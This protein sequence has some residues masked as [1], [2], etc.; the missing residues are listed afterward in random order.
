MGSRWVSARVGF[1]VWVA[2]TSTRL[3]GTPPFEAAFMLSLLC[4]AVRFG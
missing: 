3:P 4:T 2:G 1:A